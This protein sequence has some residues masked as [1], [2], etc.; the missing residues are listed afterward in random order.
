[1]WHLLCMLGT[2]G[3]MPYFI[4]RIE[5]RFFTKVGPHPSD[6]TMRTDEVASF[7]RPHALEKDLWARKRAL[8]DVDIWSSQRGCDID[9]DVEKTDLFG[10]PDRRAKIL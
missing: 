2:M 6:W 8:L 9:L 3:S 4:R 1:M 10:D 7:A 5:Q